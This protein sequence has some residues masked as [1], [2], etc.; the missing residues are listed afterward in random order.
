MGFID[1][2]RSR[3]LQRR[4]QG[5]VEVWAAPPRSP[6]IL[7]PGIFGSA[8]SAPDS[9]RLIWGD[10][11][12][13]YAAESQ[14]DALCLS[15]EGDGGPSVAIRGIIERITV[16]P[17][18]LAIPVYADLIAMLTELL[19]YRLS[20][21]G[22]EGSLVLHAYDF[23]LDS[24]TILEGLIRDVHASAARSPSR[25][26]TLLGHSHGG[27]LAAAAARD[28]R[29]ASVITGAVTLAAAFGGSVDNLRLMT[30][31]YQPGPLGTCFDAEMML[32]THCG[33]QTLPV[34]GPPLFV[35]ARGDP[36]DLDLYDAA[37]WRKLGL[38]VFSPEG[39][40][41]LERRASRSG[42]RGSPDS[43]LDRRET[44]L[45]AALDRAKLW[46][47]GLRARSAPGAPVYRIGTS[48]HPTLA[49]VP[50]I[51]R[52]GTLA[53]TFPGP[54]AARRLLGRTVA[55]T[56]FEP[57]DGEVTVTSLRHG[58]V[59]PVDEH[60]QGTASHRTMINDDRTLV[61]V[62]RALAHLEQ[63]G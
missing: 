40:A 60:I 53:G 27:V 43:R 37:T 46:H 50:V 24:R 44:V 59:P 56:L 11:R 6:L 58:A 55:S 25:R 41:G 28:P 20:T 62:I 4:L 12:S 52:G 49:R 54:A 19:G 21:P 2:F 3:R 39:R 36:M 31:G 18:L 5:A 17:G 22:R 35:D 23:R 15:L 9:R 47:E 29:C 57:G 26:V 13:F 30:S 16:V 51:R 10:L 1:R 7:V 33:I 8:L 48:S 14:G 38:G 61:A 32:R 63:R 34:P 42:E 45:A